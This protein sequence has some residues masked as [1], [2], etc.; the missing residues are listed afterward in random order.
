M[1]G[2]FQPKV[3][4]LPVRRMQ[5]E[6]EAVKGAFP[7]TNVESALLFE[8]PAE[9][10]ARVLRTL[11]PSCKATIDVK[12]RPSANAR[13]SVRL[14]S[15]LLRVRMADVMEQAPAPVLESLAYLLLSKL[16][17]LRPAASHRRRYRM[18]L[19]RQDVGKRLHTAR[20]ERGYKAASGPAG[21]HFSLEA[22]FEDLNRKFFG[23]MLARP[24]L[25]WSRHCSRT[26]LGHY[27]PAHHMIVISRVF[28]RAD[29]P[30]DLIEYVMY[31]EMLHLL[32]PPEHHAGRRVIHTRAFREAEKQ[33]PEIRG[34]KAKLREFLGR[35]GR[36][37]S[38]QD[39][40]TG[41]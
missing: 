34:V 12:F 35:E 16:F 11:R 5:V 38:G 28:D 9:L 27:D 40:L 37:G 24:N 1:T 3:V 31:H 4:M 30:R 7:A 32:H 20:R 25:G 17:R 26:R 18:W 10:F 39:C 13:S 29:M 6:D 14:E 19:Q 22:V 36:K 23:G 21:E 33:F 41:A 15:G 2:R 8:S